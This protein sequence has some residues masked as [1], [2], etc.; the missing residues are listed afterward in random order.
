MPLRL[1]IR[2]H[3]SR[4][5]ETLPL[6]RFEI[7]GDALQVSGPKGWRED[8]PLTEDDLLAEARAWRMLPLSISLL[9]D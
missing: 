5:D 4:S 1:A 2:L 6:L 8:Y 3:R 9:D 7:D